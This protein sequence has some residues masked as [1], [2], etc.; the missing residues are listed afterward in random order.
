M[1]MSSDFKKYQ[2]FAAEITALLHRERPAH[3][4]ELVQDHFVP[5]GVAGIVAAY[6][7]FTTWMYRF[8]DLK[9][10]PR[11]RWGR[12]IKT[13]T[14]ISGFRLRHR[15]GGRPHTIR[16]RVS[17]PEH[18]GSAAPDS[19]ATRSCIMSWFMERAGCFRPSTRRKSTRATMTR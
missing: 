4:R 1:A 9:K 6:H 13:A 3:A 11:W 2:D 10:R 15:C 7:P 5:T 14:A 8:D 17:R 12:P 19:R 16:A 18:Q